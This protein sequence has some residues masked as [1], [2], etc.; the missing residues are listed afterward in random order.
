VHNQSKD[1]VSNLRRLAAIGSTLMFVVGCGIAGQSPS[2]R[3]STAA[4]QPAQSTA[5]S[6]RPTQSASSATATGTPSATE[7]PSATPTQAPP[8][9]PAP[10]P[11][12]QV[13]FGNWPLYIDIDEENGGYPT[14]EAFTDE[15]GIAVS[16]QED[17]NDN[18]E[19]FGIIQPDLA[20]GNPTGYDIITMTDWMIERMGRLGYLEELD[21]S[22]LPNF[23]AAASDLFTDPWYDPGNRYSIPYVGGIVGIAYNPTLTGRPITTF[24]DLLDPAFAGRVGMFSEMRDTMSLTLLSMGV[25]PE[26]ATIEDAQAAHDKLLAP[27]QAGQFRNFYGNDYY[28]ALAAGDLAVTIAWSGDIS[29]MRLYDNPDIEFIIPDSGGML[30]VDNMAIP[31]NAQHPTDAHMLM[32][33]W[34]ELDNAA[35]L[36]EYIGYFSPVDGIG[37]RV[38]EDAQAARDEGDDEW[39]DQLEIIADDVVIDDEQ[40]ENVY[41]YKILTEDEERQWNDLFNEVVTG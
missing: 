25:V 37:E 21:H 2:Q 1:P 30:F 23:T 35:P 13:V 18:E 36:I 19:F 9:T 26:E 16:Y 8:A 34:Y 4:S 33:Y 17:I 28:D 41:T 10:T 31:K 39:A 12:G 7:A 32:D 11:A 27:A 14:L 6:Q 29:Q 22:Q 38:L 15:T 3:A 24:D 20:A 40:L 5:A